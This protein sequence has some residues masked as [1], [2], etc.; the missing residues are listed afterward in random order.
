[1]SAL[2]SPRTTLRLLALAQASVATV[3]TGRPDDANRLVGQN[4]RHTPPRWIVRVLGLRQLAQAGLQFA[5]PTPVVAL[6]GAAVDASHAASMVWLAARSDRYRR[7]AVLSG[8]LAAASA[9]ALAAT[10]VA[11]ARSR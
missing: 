6:S 2:T 10:A 11:E 4:P 1:M 9:V 7:A 3:L 5:K 8:G